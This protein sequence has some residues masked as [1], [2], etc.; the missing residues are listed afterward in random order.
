MLAIINTLITAIGGPLAYTK[1]KPTKT[2]QLYIE[3]L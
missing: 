2:P 3:P 1:K